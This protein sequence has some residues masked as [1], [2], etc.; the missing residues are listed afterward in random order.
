M[1]VRG[2]A[3]L[4]PRERRESW[5]GD[6]VR[7]IVHEPAGRPNGRHPGEFVSLATLLGDAIV[8]RMIRPPEE[9]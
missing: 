2:D 5:Q 1:K 6:R 8:P 9:R 3:F 7:G 4:C